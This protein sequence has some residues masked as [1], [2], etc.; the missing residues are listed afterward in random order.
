MESKKLE[1][2]LNL[3]ELRLEVEYTYYPKYKSND[4]DIPDEQERIVIERVLW[5]GINIKDALTDK[6]L[7]SILEDIMEEINDLKESFKENE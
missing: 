5:N 1:T 3:D 4:R 7:K 6:Q 2:Y